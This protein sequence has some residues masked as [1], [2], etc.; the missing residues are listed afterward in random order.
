[1]AVGTRQESTAFIGAIVVVTISFYLRL[2]Q[3]GSRQRYDVVLNLLCAADANLRP[4]LKR[5]SRKVQLAASRKVG[6]DMDMSYRLQLRDPARSHDLQAELEDD[7][8]CAAGFSVHARRRVGG[9]GDGSYFSHSHAAQAALESLPAGCAAGAQLLGLRG[10]T[11]LLWQREARFGALVGEV[12]AASGA[13][14]RPGRMACWSPPEN[15]IWQLFDTVTKGDGDW[16]LNDKM[17]QVRI[18]RTVMASRASA[19]G[20]AGRRCTV[21][22]DQDRLQQTHLQNRLR[23]TWEIEQRR[24]ERLQQA[25]LMRRTGEPESDPGQPGHVGRPGPDS[26]RAA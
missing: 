26:N 2:T 18:A 7:A 6:D 25:A 14:S 23:V 11:L 17:L 21:T 3:F 15:T 1:M 4:C 10:L 13:M 12:E 16:L 20:V 19:G 5:H 22:L 9:L 24:V 8:G